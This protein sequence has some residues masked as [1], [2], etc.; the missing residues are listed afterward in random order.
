MPFIDTNSNYYEGDRQGADT[1]VPQRPSLSHD[2]NGTEWVL[3]AKRAAQAAIDALEA[4]QAQRL[5][6]R[7]QREFYLAVFSLLNQTSAPAFTALKSIDDAIKAE[8]TK[9]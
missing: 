6:A 8:R 5:T 3:N 9:L 2:W 7:A 1:I 4:Q